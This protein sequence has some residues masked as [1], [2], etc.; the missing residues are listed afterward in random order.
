MRNALSTIL[1]V[2]LTMGM[3]AAE[4]EK[5]EP[6]PGP[7]YT[8]EASLPEGWPAPGPFN[9][10]AEKQY[11]AYRGAFT[12][13]ERRTGAFMTLFK[14]IQ[15][16]DIP[17]TS[18][19]EMG[20]GVEVG[21]LEMNTMGF[22]YRKPDVG[23]LGKDGDDVVVTD[24]PAMAVLSFAWMGPNDDANRNAAKAALD[25]ALADRQIEAKGFRLLGYNGPGVP[26]EKRTHEL[27]SILP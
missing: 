19:V 6:A 26:V 17:M 13:D 22:L 3:P 5:T 27:Q 7:N 16:K 8:E 25:K 14:H 18:P 21:G 4:P 9:E 11:P 1:L 20:M 23:E 24:V 10:V 2:G 15:S 12:S